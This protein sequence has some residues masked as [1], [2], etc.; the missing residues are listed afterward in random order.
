MERNIIKISSLYIAQIKT[1][2]SRPSI[3]N[4]SEWLKKSTL[5]SLCVLLF[6]HRET[7]LMM[8]HAVSRLSVNFSG[9]S[10]WFRRISWVKINIFSTKTQVIKFFRNISKLLEIV[11]VYL[12]LEFHL[13]FHFDIAK[14][15]HSF[16]Q[17]LVL[18]YIVEFFPLSNLAY[19]IASLK[20]FNAC[21][22]K[23]CDTS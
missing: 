22:Y 1:D 12:L 5:T 10:R 3:I 9:I 14:F 21:T 13:F 8:T 23:V 2:I 6:N 20:I 17:I 19:L 18:T 4:C 11:S 16:S 7:S 15:E